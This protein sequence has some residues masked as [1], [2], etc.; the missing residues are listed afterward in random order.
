MKKRETKKMKKIAIKRVKKI[1]K[2]L[3][4]KE[5]ILAGLGLSAT[6]VGGAGLVAPRSAMV[7]TITRAA[8]DIFSPKEAQASSKEKNIKV[9]LANDPALAQGLLKSGLTLGAS[10]FTG[11]AGGAVANKF[12]NMLF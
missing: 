5:K 3:T 12:G 6:L 11:G 2:P 8:K 10:I 7:R 4:A 9:D 1:K